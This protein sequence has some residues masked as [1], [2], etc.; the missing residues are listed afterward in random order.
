MTEDKRSG[1]VVGSTGNANAVDVDT[2]VAVETPINVDASD[3]DI[4]ADVNRPVDVNEPF[5]VDSAVAVDEPFDVDARN[6]NAIVDVDSP[7]DIGSSVVKVDDA[8]TDVDTP[9][10]VDSPVAVGWPVRR[11]VTF[12]IFTFETDVITSFDLVF[13]IVVM[14]YEVVKKSDLLISDIL[15]VISEVDSVNGMVDSEDCVVDSLILIDALVAVVVAENNVISGLIMSEIINVVFDS[16]E[17][18]QTDVLVWWMEYSVNSVIPD[19]MPTV[20]DDV[21]ILVTISSS[22]FVVVLTSKLALHS[23]LEKV[24]VEH[25]SSDSGELFSDK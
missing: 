14:I 4:T 3:V 25:S 10:D 18:S 24:Q 20:F 8:I 13:D 11:Y 6:D 1:I 2:P 23:F 9:V 22:E 5:E 16:V 7:V 21:I 17:S 15:V 19:V 12:N